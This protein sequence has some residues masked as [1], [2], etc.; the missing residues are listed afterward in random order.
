M[1]A[2]NIRA[3]T[4]PPPKCLTNNLIEGE[5][6]GGNAQVGPIKT[7]YQYGRQTQP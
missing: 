2:I 5:N 4:P 1:Y 6:D 7:D 3:S